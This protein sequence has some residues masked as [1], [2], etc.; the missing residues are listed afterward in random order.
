M[1]H[2]D[3]NISSGVYGTQQYGKT[4]TKFF[5]AQINTSVV[6]LCVKSLNNVSLI[7]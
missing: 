2:K 3:S 5:P 7:F 4:G 6:F 1:Y